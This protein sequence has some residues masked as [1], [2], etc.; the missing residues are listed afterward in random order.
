MKVSDCCGAATKVE[1]RSDRPFVYDD[2]Y[3]LLVPV[4]ICTKCEKAVGVNSNRV[5]EG[6]PEGPG[7]VQ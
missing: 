3:E 1:Y 5:P 7:P 4:L 6:P 2:L